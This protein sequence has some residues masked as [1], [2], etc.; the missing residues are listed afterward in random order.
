[1]LYEGLFSAGQFVGL[2]LGGGHEQVQ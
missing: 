2:V 1:V